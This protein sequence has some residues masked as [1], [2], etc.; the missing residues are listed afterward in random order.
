MWNIL[1]RIQ[2]LSL[3]PVA[4]TIHRKNASIFL[5]FVIF[6]SFTLPYIAAFVIL[7][8]CRIAPSTP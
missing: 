8:Q 3:F 2:Y 6:F 5:F 7:T 1:V 4:Y